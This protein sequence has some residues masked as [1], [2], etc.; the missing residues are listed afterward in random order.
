M[1]HGLMIR[2]SSFPDES[3]IVETVPAIEDP[4]HKDVV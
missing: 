1:L 4:S 3:V 2:M